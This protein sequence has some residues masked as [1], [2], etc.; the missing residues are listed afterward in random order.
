MQTQEVSFEANGNQ[1]AGAV[2]LPDDAQ[3]TC[4]LVF[5]HGDGP[6]DRSMWGYYPPL[7]DA[8]T[9][10]GVA[11]LIWDK[12]GCGESPGEYRRF[13]SFYDRAA[14]IPHALA[15]TAEIANAC[16]AVVIWGISQA[17]WVIPIAMGNG[18]E[19]DGFIN[20]SG[21]AVT[22]TSQSLF[23]VRKLLTREGYGKEEIERISGVYSSVFGSVHDFQSYEEFAD[24]LGSVVDVKP[25]S[26]MGWTH[27]TEDEFLRAKAH[28]SWSY[29]PMPQL[30]RI[31]V[32]TMAIFG[33]ADEN[34]DATE[35]FN[36]YQEAFEDRPSLL[37]IV[38]LH[39]ADHG[40]R[41]ADTGGFHPDFIPAIVRHCNRAAN[42]PIQRTPLRGVTDL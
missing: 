14:E 35:S 27:I 39:S 29:D 16:D 23:F 42:K 6:C 1:I 25:L 21:P 22:A 3:A 30:R 28:K 32:S 19:C 10:Q 31:D 41:L 40:I 38:L 34:V 11:C 12:P 9:A 13:E 4:L 2:Y 8:L 33:D 7:I 26:N 17:G 18:L 37:D 20:V 24:S 5:V 36:L 15:A